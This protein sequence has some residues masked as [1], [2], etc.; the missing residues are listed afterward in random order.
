MSTKTR[1]Q[2]VGA[3]EQSTWKGGVVTGLAGGAVM[4]VMLSMMMTPV[5]TNAIPALYGLSGGVAGWVIHM[6]NSAIFGVVF[7]AIAG[8][9]DVESDLAKS[10][11]LGVVYGIA[12]WVVFAAI[13]MPIW[14]GTVG[15]PEAPPLPNFNPMSLVGH[16]VYGLVVGAVFPFVRS[17]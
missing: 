13:V 14:L 6:S 8:A 7:A 12:L 3:T 10:V 15:F 9:T 11:G 4:G 2:T 1:T 17:L 5:I 16:V